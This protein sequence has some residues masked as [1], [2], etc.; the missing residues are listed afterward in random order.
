MAKQVRTIYIDDLTGDQ[1]DDVKTVRFGIDGREYEI[2]LNAENHDKL[3]NLLNPYILAA[4]RRGRSAPTARKAATS[5]SADSATIRE[6]AKQQGFEVSERGRVPAN[7]RASYEKA[8][9]KK[10]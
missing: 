2:D 6:W 1:S 5:A 8:H 10:K 7:V 9:A 4:R 3:T